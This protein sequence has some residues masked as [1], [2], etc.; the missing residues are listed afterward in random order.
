MT[1]F[2][3]TE[4]QTQLSKV[5]EQARTQ[6]EVRIKLADGEEFVLRPASRSPLDVGSIKLDPPITAEEIA[7]F[8]REGES[9][10]DLPA[11]LRCYHAPQRK[12]F[13][14]V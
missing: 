14:F 11:T 8:V 6:G 7:R 9:A 2:T 13:L 10:A 4:A 12:K 1:V 5:L 3:D